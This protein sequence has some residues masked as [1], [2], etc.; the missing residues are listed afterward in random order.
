MGYEFEIDFEGLYIKN[1][2][3]LPELIRELRNNPG[4]S[5][6][7]DEIKISDIPYN[8]KEKEY[9][10]S[11]RLECGTGCCPKFNDIENWLGIF[12]KYCIGDITIKGE[13]NIWVEVEFKD[14]KDFEEHFFTESVVEIPADYLDCGFEQFDN[15]YRGY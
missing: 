12:N 9:P 8:F 1:K 10:N 7:P 6:L 5:F 13:D 3:D 11:S 4:T 2:D 15:K 14:K